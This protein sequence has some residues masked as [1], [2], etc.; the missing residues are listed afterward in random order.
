MHHLTVDGSIRIARRVYWSPERGVERP[1]D[2]WLGIEDATVSR[3]A[4]QLCS[5]AAMAGGSFAKGTEVLWRLGQLR[6]SD[7]HLRTLAE[8]EGRHVKDA[9]AEGRVGPDWTAA[10]CRTPEGVNRIM[11]GADGVMVPVITA[12]EKAK[13]RGRRQRRRK[14]RRRPLWQRLFKGSEHPWKEFK[15]AG[16]YDPPKERVWAFGTAGGPHV[17]G[18]RMR[19]AAGRLKINEAQERVAVTDGA[20]WIRGQLQTRLPMVEVRIL[21]YF[22][23]MEHVGEAAVIGFGA[24]RLET[25]R[26]IEAVSKAALEEGVAGLLVAIRDTLRSLRSP[27]KREAFRK[28]EQYVANHAEMLDYPTYRARGFDIGSGPTES[29]CRTL[30]TR[31]K[32]GGKRWDTPNAEALMALAALKHSRLWDTY[33]AVPARQVA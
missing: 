10:D 5:L 18:R 25:M 17:I 6:V 9:L 16:F 28:L 24:G 26:W 31:L 33:W 22:H 19:R 1:V 12:A 32:G 3:G 8:A 14:A 23:L 11:V 27:A 30:T 20:P 13:R 15:I 7:E 29:L 21:D 2:G 4:R